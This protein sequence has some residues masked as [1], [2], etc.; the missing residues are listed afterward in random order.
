MSAAEIQEKFRPLFNP[1]TV[2]VVGASTRGTGRQSVFIRRLKQFGF[3]GKIYLIHPSASEIDG[4]PAF[5]SFAAVPEP[6][7]YANI[8]IPA[9]QVPDLLAN[10]AGRVRFAQVISSGF[11]EVDG[12][13]DLED[14]L[15]AAARAGGTR[16]IGP[17]CLGMYSPRGRITFTEIAPK[18]PG[19]IGI[20][21]QSGGLGG[22]IIRQG[23]FRGLKFS[24]LVT[25]GNCADLDAA[26][27]LE[28]YLADD[29]TRVIGLYIETARDGRRL[30]EL[31]RDA[32]GKKA[33]RHPQGRAHATG[34]HGRG[35]AHRRA[36]RRSA[37]LA[38]SGA[39]DG[40]GNRRHARRV[41]GRAVD[42]P[43]PDAVA[44]SP[45][46]TGGS[47]RQRRWHKRP[48]RR[49]LLRAWP[50][51]FCIRQSDFRRPA[52][53][54]PA[55]GQQH[56]KPVRL[57]A[58]NTAVG[59]RRARRERS[60]RHLLKSPHRRGGSSYQYRGL[61]RQGV[62]G[63]ARCPPAGR[64]ARADPLR[65]KRSFRPGVAIGW[66]RTCRCPSA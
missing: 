13:Q 50:R 2:A 9:A 54:P 16:V 51:R 46:P 64:H 29:D 1:K 40:S 53:P 56:R 32:G 41:P 21:S 6:I 3:D 26:D 35:F 48:G 4:L 11:S 23:A 19:S 52:R 30:F 43:G 62:A 60:R 24:G 45:D 25:V 37:G 17:N 28:F 55:A 31:M 38:C 34:R 57:P 7:D 33:D 8:A 65:G 12:G 36:R 49:L 44:G 15:R 14:S 39:P 58:G 66:Q 10:S 47:V 61:C 22:D 42:L 27:F 18:E 59:E 20:V 5:P 63:G